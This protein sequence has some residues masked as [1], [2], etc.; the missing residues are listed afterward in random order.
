MA[1][2]SPVQPPLQAMIE[3]L[4]DLVNG[5]ASLLRRGCY[6]TADMMIEVGAQPYFIAINQGRITGFERGP[7]VMK[8]WSFAVR[9]SEEAWDK[10]WQ[11]L[12]PPNFHDIFALAKQGAFCIDGD[13]RPLITNLLYFKA[14]LAAPRALRA[15]AS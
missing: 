1:E 14:L 10:F 2:T 4:P 8:S 7:I 13:Y 11:P 9:G 5:D 15:K 12:P 6:V 3:R